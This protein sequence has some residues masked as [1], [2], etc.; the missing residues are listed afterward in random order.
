MKLCVFFVFQVF[1]WIGWVGDWALRWTEGNEVI[2]ITF[3]MFVFPVIMNALQY[4]VID[5]FIKDRK[6]GVNGHTLLPGEDED[7]VEDQE[8]CRGQLNGEAGGYKSLSSSS[9]DGETKKKLGNAEEELRSSEDMDNNPTEYDPQLDGE[10]S[11]K[12]P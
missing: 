10:G 1:P 11:K 6:P 7:E 2:Q 12:T 9:T 3:V 4:Y 5:T 8:V